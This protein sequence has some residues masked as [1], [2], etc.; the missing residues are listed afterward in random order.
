MK[1][2]KENLNTL[3]TILFLVLIGI[4]LLV[5]P[6]TFGITIIKVA[7]VLFAALGV[8]DL[9]K[10]FRAEPSE[11][12]KGQG[13]SSGVTMISIGCFCFFGSGWF[14]DAFPVLAVLYGL[15]QILIGFRKAQRTVD[16]LR[17]KQPM[18]YLKAIS[19]GISLLFGFIIV[20]NPGMTFMSIWVFTGVTLIIEGVFDAAML[21]LQQKK[22]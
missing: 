1:F 9:V 10:Y 19:A 8:F 18:W 5:D 22:A 2:I 17:T 15:F 13:F 11:A 6:A 14:K 7:G 3:L 12:A 4:L 20:L 21:F 16:A